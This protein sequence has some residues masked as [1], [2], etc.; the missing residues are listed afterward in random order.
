MSLQPV[1][2]ALHRVKSVLERRPATGEHDDAPASARWERGVRS[3]A[4]HANGTRIETDM[5]TE[6][7]GTGDRVTVTGTSAVAERP[8]V[9]FAVTWTRYAPS[10]RSLPSST[11]LRAPA[12]R[13]CLGS[14]CATVAPPASRTLTATLAFALSVYEMVVVSAWPSPFGVIVAVPLALG[15]CLAVSAALLPS[16]RSPRP[17]A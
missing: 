9:A 10:A 2:A 13:H 5:S 4:S 7:G 8:P 17:T 15:A 12:R 6:V 1:A 16:S 11:T 3:V 14:S